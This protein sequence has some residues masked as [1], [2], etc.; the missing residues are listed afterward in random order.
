MQHEEIRP[1]ENLFSAPATNTGTNKS[2]IFR[3]ED[4]IAEELATLH[5][6]FA[7]RVMPDN[8]LSQATPYIDQGELPDLDMNELTP[9]DFCMGSN[10]LER[11]N[12]IREQLGITVIPA[13]SEKRAIIAHVAYHL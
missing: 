13:N 4:D 1:A 8:Y 6:M 12:R 11:I 7:G 2:N 9:E 5:R 10:L 3:R